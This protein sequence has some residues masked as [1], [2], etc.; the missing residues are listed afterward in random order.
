[1][2]G[3]SALVQLQSIGL[4]GLVIS[5]MLAQSTDAALRSEVQSCMGVMAYPINTIEG[6]DQRGAP[7]ASFLLDA[8]GAALPALSWR[9]GQDTGGW[10]WDLQ[11]IMPNVE[12]NELFYPMLCLWRKELSDSGG[13]GTF[14]GGNG[15]EMAIVAHKTE[16]INIATCTAE[17]AIPGPGLSGGYPTSTNTFA[18]ITGADMRA[19]WAR[20][21]RM[22]TT[23]GEVEDGETTWIAS[24]SFDNSILPSDVWVFGWASAGGYGDP[25]ERDPAAVADDVIAGRVSAAWGREAYGVVLSADGAVDGSATEARR[26][27]IVAE[28]LLEGRRWKGRTEDGFPA[29]TPGSARDGRLSEHL[30]IVDGEIRSGNVALGPATGNY[31][32]HALVRDLPLTAANPVVRDPAIYVDHAVR[33]RQIICPRTGR[34]LQTEIAVDDNPPQWDLRPGT[35]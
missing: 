29:G 25:I 34:L 1:V 18:K 13:A 33:F 4:G 31:K 23:P 3:A 20:T 8:C 32:L 15:G 28:R 12:D 7:Y 26:A 35:I 19:Q 2:S 5:K 6:V 21:G 24:K 27:E 16:R 9:D 14:R 10:P 11:S 30:H 17:V 22:P